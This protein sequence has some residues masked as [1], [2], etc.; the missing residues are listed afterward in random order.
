M[1]FYVIY[2]NKR[3]SFFKKCAIILCRCAGK[4]W[5]NPLF[6][7]ILGG[8]MK[9]KIRGLVEEEINNAE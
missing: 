9:E 1:L 7:V 4:E 3:Y 8:F 6:N 2:I 5:A